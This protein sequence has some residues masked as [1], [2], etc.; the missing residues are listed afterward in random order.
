MNFLFLK[1]IKFWVILIVVGSVLATGYFAVQSY[2]RTVKQNV[3]LKGALKASQAS[4]KALEEASKKTN[5][6][7]DRNDTTT[8]TIV[9][10]TT[11][12]EREIHEVPITT[13]CTDSPAISVALRGLRANREASSERDL[14]KELVP[15]PSK[16]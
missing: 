16:P 2:Q 7:I 13:K 12:L 11:K 10:K 6:A 8:R 3:E 15:V 9:E 5:D 14:P 4:V 1:S